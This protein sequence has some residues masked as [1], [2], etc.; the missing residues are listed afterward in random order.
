MGVAT[1]HK[2]ASRDIRPF[3]GTAAIEQAVQGAE[4]RLFDDAA[5]SV[6]ESY[7]I[8]PHD[9]PRLNVVVRPNIDKAAV[10]SGSIPKSKLELVISA[11]NPFLK[12]TCPVLRASMSNAI[13]EE[14]VVGAEILERLG[15]GSTLSVDVAL[16]L[17]KEMPKK[18]GT[19]Y[20]VG[21]WLSKKTFN[22]RPPAITDDFDIEPMDDEGWRARGLPVKTLFYVDYFGFVNE[23]VSKDKQMA[24]VRIHSDVYK[25]LSVDT[26]AKV[27]KPL[28]S[29]L[30]AEIAGQILALSLADW[31]QSEEAEARSPLAAFMKR[32]NRVQPCTLSELKA[33]VKEPGM[34]RLRAILHADQH[35]VRSVAEA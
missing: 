28:M 17:A 20:L 3:F 35:S 23:E 11:F 34:P 29:F 5:F 4:V 32:I 24:K 19:P 1:W 25:K 2:S 15:G 12:R 13:P 16:C 7:V 8:E 26:N 6:E 31:E 9:A 30:A 21:H 22:L 18:P 27:A 10:A 14:V 33:L